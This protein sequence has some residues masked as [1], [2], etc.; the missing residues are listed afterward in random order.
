MKC[1]SLFLLSATFLISTN[2]VIAQPGSETEKGAWETFKPELV[3]TKIIGELFKIGSSCV[4]GLAVVD[5]LENYFENNFGKPPK[6]LSLCFYLVAAKYLY[7]LQSLI[8][9]TVA[10][11]IA[12][13][14]AALAKNA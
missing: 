4:G 3:S 10:R 2:Y 7:K 13:N 1:F 14:K 5:V 12:S 9:S 6:L 8:D 11:I